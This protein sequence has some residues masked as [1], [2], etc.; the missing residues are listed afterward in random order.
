MLLP[1][2]SVGRYRLC[3]ESARTPDRVGFLGSAWRD[4]FG[5]ALKRAVCVTGLPECP[6]CMLY[7]GCTYPY[8]F[9]T[10]P[11]LGSEKMRTYPAAP[12]PFVLVLPAQGME[13]HDDGSVALGINLFGRANALLAHV[14]FA[15]QQAGQG[16]VGPERPSYRLL[17]AEQYD[18]HGWMP[19]LAQGGYSNRDQS[20]CAIRRRARRISAS[21]S[22]SLTSKPS[23]M[24]RASRWPTSTP[25][26]P[27]PP[28]P[29]R[30]LP[31]CAR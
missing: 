30:S 11:P 19:I 4:A 3:F 22:R 23:P 31:Q 7:R 16:G 29:M 13:A 28:S 14:V 5:H 25:P 20:R 18:T 26:S 2:L 10:P 12:H 17:R 1:R 21:R 24:P 8:V 15:L 27:T 6:Q 9:E